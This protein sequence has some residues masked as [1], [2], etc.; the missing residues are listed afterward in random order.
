MKTP[1]GTFLS[2][3]CL[4]LVVMLAAC[5]PPDSVGTIKAA[6]LERRI[7]SGDAPLILDVRRPGEYAAGHVP[8][9][10]NIPHSEIEA[11]LD[12]LGPARDREIVVYC[13]SGMRAAMA[14]KDLVE[15]GFRNLLDLDGHM[16]G[17]EE[18]GL[19]VELP[20]DQG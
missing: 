10:I 19:P 13:K 8:G 1:A 4:L 20:D 2:I 17:W 5:S 14:E 3:F 9:A 16:Q 18:A 11:R 6:D 12:E 15:A 7:A